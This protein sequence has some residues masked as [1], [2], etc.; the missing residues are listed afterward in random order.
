MNILFCDDPFDVKSVDRDY[1]D[2]FTGAVE[3]RFSIHL[4]S[5][6]SLTREADAKTATRRIKPSDT[7]QELLYRGW[8][9]KPKQYSML[10]EALLQKN[11]RLINSPSQYQNCHYLPDSCKFI[12]GLTPKTVWLNLANPLVDYDKVF[13]IIKPFGSG[14]LIIKDFV[15]SQKHYWDTACF[16]PS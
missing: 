15:K 14:P 3:N 9:L 12:E 1:S 10:Y 13:E 6:E 5:F 16:I 7:L 8:M 2:E 11:Y 4:F